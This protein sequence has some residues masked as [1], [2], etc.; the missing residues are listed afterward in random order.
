MSLDGMFTHSLVNELNETLLDGQ[1]TRIDQPYDNETLLTIRANR[2]NYK[3][4]LSA[5]PQY[6]RAHISEMTYKN[7]DQPPQFCM[8]LRK[9]LNRA[10]LVEIKQIENDR[11]IAFYFSNRNEIGDD[12]HLILY[13]ELMGRHSNIL[14]VDEKENKIMEAIRHVPKSQNSYRTL[15]PGAPFIPSPPQ[16]NV[17]PFTS[18]KQ[19]ILEKL[20]EADGDEFYQKVQQTLQGVGRDTAKELALLSE[21]KTEN[22]KGILDDFLYK[23]DSAI[24]PTLYEQKTKAFLT[25]IK[26]T[27]YA[28]SD[29]STTYDTLS[30]LMDAFYSEKANRDYV[31]QVSKELEQLL[32]NELSKGKKKLGKQAKELA[33]T[34]EADDYRIKGEVLTAYMHIVEQ[35]QE[36]ITLPNFYDN[37]REITISLDPQL[38]PAENAQRLFNRYRKLESRKAT[39]TKLIKTTKSTNEYLESTLTQLD[40]AS[41]EDV[42]EI[43]QEL[44]EEGYIKKKRKQRNKKVKKGKP[45]HFVSNDGDEILVGRNN[46]QNDELTLRKAS[47]SHIW[48]HTKE[49]P[50]SHVIIQNDNPSEETIIQAAELAAYFSKARSSSNVPVDYVEVKQVHKPNGAKPGFVIYEGQQTVYVTPSRNKTNNLAKTDK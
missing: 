30:Q 9:Y 39:L 6:A 20:E 22:F 12:T 42:P 23:I 41:P 16:D 14:L 25:P 11:V 29:Y 45:R 38:S 48:L 2:T 4:L 36:E 8:V 40:I 1:V 44:I 27:F 17:N 47:K 15:L 19:V 37:E 26:Y 33:A 49:I 13:V 21:D 28:E 34:K 24:E 3:L 35:G 18:D 43:R 5:H 10:R 32:S 31:H 46:K 7:P 50:G